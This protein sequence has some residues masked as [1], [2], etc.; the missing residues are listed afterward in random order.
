[1]KKKVLIFGAGSVGAHHTYSA[2][3]NNCEVIDCCISNILKIWEIH[4]SPI[5]IIMLIKI[6][7]K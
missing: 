6:Y 7:F 1:M 3:S 2:I 4:I 5:K